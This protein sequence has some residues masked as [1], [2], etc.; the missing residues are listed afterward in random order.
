MCSQ[1]GCREGTQK[2]R[3]IDLHEYS[4]LATPCPSRRQTKHFIYGH[5]FFKRYPSDGKRDGTV[6]S[7]QWL[8]YRPGN[9][10]TV[11]R[12]LDEVTYFSLLQSVQTGTDAFTPPPP[13]TLR[14]GREADDST[15]S[16]AKVKHER[17]Y[18]SIPPYAFTDR[19]VRQLD[20][21]LY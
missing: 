5:L 8:R 20:H 6:S 18:I 11:V 17:S 15:Q 10:K 3:C 12:F 9:R 1:S 19:K 13:P 21:S 4:Q 14:T 16:S 2:T 7:V